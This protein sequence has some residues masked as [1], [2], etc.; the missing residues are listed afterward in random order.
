MSLSF[1]YALLITTN[2]PLA[3]QTH[4]W[5][6]ATSS[7]Q[8]DNQEKAQSSSENEDGPDEANSESESSQG[9]TNS[10]RSESNA[11]K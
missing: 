4:S 1:L 2:S 5:V 10:E 9:D 3:L 7:Q 6:Y 11:K 8:E